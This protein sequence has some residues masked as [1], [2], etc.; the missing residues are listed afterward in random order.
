M[1][2]NKKIIGFIHIQYVI[3]DEVSSNTIK[4]QPKEK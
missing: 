3:I 4:S 2:F 1:I